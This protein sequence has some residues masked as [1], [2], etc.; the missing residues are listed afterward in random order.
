MASTDKHKTWNHE[1][2]AIL[3]QR[4]DDIA[5]H[6]EITHYFYA[7]TS[8]HARSLIERLSKTQHRVLV[9]GESREYDGYVQWL[10][11]TKTVTV[12]SDSVLDEMTD[13]CCKLCDGLGVEYDGWE[14]DIVKLK[15][16]HQ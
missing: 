9:D 3:E 6:H 2:R 14:T 8:D 11:L 5:L 4:G 12:P 13:E 15:P 1:I 16:G 7:D 10:V